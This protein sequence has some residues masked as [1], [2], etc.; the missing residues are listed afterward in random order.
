M[1]NVVLVTIVD[2]LKYLL[3][4]D[5]CVTLREFSSLKNLVEQF[6]S[7][8]DFCD[9]IVSLIIFEELIHLD[10]VWMVNF[11]KNVDLIEE[12]A[13]LIFVHVAL[14]KDFDSSLSI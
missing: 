10:D 1:N 11:L 4:E 8:T 9:K 5:S 6:S 14:S 7:L 2:A 3:H 12:H 13:L